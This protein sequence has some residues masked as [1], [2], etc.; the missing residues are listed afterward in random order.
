[1]TRIEHPLLAWLTCPIPRLLHLTLMVA[2]C[3]LS[4]VLAYVKCELTHFSMSAQ[5]ELK[6][7]VMSVV[8]QLQDFESFVVG[9]SRG[10]LSMHI[11][12]LPG[13]TLHAGWHLA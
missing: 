2:G 4:L 13:D 6:C 12:G 1:M 11:P 10:V 7:F 9:G 5:K 8:W 3:I